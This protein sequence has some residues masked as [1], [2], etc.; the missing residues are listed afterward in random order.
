M[1]RI[2][3][4]SANVK[5]FFARELDSGDVQPLQDE[6]IQAPYCLLECISSLGGA[7]PLFFQNQFSADSAGHGL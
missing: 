5:S 6:R 4:V 1:W 3:V 7:S 2:G